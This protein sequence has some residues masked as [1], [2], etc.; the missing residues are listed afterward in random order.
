MSILNLSIK[1]QHIYVGKPKKQRPGPKVKE[2]FI[3]FLFT[4]QPQKT[5]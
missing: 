1:P 3:N 5:F 2:N 4:S